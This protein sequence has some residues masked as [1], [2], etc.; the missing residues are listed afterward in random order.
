MNKTLEYKSKN[1]ATHHSVL[2]VV[3]KL[4]KDGLSA[5]MGVEKWARL[6]RALLAVMTAIRQ[7]SWRSGRLVIQSKREISWRT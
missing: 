7:V 5:A 4:T 1:N 6:G 3:N 2:S